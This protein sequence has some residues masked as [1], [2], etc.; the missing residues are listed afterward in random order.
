[1]EPN[2]ALD[3]LLLHDA[4]MELLLAELITAKVV[5]FDSLVIRPQS[6][7]KRGY[8]RDITGYEVKS[9]RK[10]KAASVLTIDTSREGL[11]DSLPEFFLHDRSPTE[12]QRPD[13]RPEFSLD[14][15]H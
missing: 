14:F 4:R 5:N 11:Y 3:K 7:F 8:S 13:Y 2:K 15:I 10:N 1:M 12:G 9:P 6:T